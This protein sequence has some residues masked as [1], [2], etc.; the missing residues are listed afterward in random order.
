MRVQLPKRMSAAVALAALAATAACAR[1]SD[2]RAGTD[3]TAA[4]TTTRDTSMGNAMGGMSRD[5][6]ANMPGMMSMPPEDRAQMRM[7]GNP[8]QDFL[9]M[10]SDHH[11]GLIAMAHLSTEGEKKGS[12]A[13][14][15]DA[16]KLDTKQ[17][18][19]LDTMQ[20]MLTRQFEDS[21]DP[22]IMPSNQ[23][24][25]D[26][27]KGQSGAAFDRTFYNNVVMHHQQ[28]I[29]M[30]DEFL[31]KLKDAK[32]RQMAE[33]M[34]RDQQRELPEFQQKAAKG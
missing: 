25:V 21:Y 12:A 24:M 16:R 26:Q 1:K 10:M 28:A 23:A 7:T 17:E 15:A 30:I 33:R 4:T 31:P 5:S 13:A 3:T 9:R 22:K 18:A 19:E 11:K 8:D 20:T 27:L 29:R 6:M 34:K 14:Q 32:I 2:D